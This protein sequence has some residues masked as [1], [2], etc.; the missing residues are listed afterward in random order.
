M[1]PGGPSPAAS[2][3][4]MAR[5][6]I[7]GIAALG[8]VALWS[9]RQFG[10]PP[11][12]AQQEVDLR[13]LDPDPGDVSPA[14]AEAVARVGAAGGGVVHLPP[15]RWLLSRSFRVDVPGVVVRGAGLR[16]TRLALPPGATFAA[17]QVA[18]DGVALE[19]LTVEGNLATWDG[20]SDGSLPAGIRV[21]DSAAD[22]S[23]RDLVVEQATGYGIGFERGADGADGVFDAFVVRDVTVL[24]SGSDGIDLKNYSSSSPACP[25]ASWRDEPPTPDACNGRRSFLRNLTVDGHGA[26]FRGVA[27]KSAVDVRGQ[28]Q[29]QAVEVLDL[30]PGALGV[31][32]RVEVG[33]APNGRGGLWSTLVGC[34]ASL[35]PG[36]PDEL[37][38][39]PVMGGDVVPGVVVEAVAVAPAGP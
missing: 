29:L 23:L 27:R 10:Q 22:V 5:D 35:A 31:H 37:P 1:S 38:G 7:L 3:R 14:L 36:G 9:A 25:T 15:G 8:A 19:R 13:D 26:L 20:G 30:A 17:V 21:V 6:G 32:F 24:G 12:P 4:R 28:R 18:A 11:P 2:R 39:V 33:G 16:A 34:F